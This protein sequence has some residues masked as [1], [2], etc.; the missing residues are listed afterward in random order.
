MVSTELHKAQ[1]I[2]MYWLLIGCKSSFVLMYEELK[3]IDEQG[4]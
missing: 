4:L 2:P 3:N 1:S